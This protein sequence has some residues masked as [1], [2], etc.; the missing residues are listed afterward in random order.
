MAKFNGIIGYAATVQTA[1]GVWTE[2]ISR[3][4]YVGDV[5]KLGRSLRASQSVNDDVVIN[6]QLS[7]VADAFAYENFFSIR[8]VEWA[9]VKW[10]VTNVE[11]KRPRLILT[12]GSVY[13]G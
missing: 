3:R 11:V 9:G 5:I 12:L 6:N 8:Y 4:A 7:V 2:E 1:P 13:N 10:K